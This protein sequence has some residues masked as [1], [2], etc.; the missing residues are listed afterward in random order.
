MVIGGQQW[1]T[2]PLLPFQP[3]ETVEEF[4]GLLLVQFKFGANRARIAS[5][6]TVFGKLLFFHQPNVAVGF[7]RRPAKVVDTL[8]ALEKR[9]DALKPVGELYR[10]RV[11]INSPALFD[12]G[13]LGD[14]QSIEQHLPADAPRAE[15]RGFPIVFFK[16]NVMFL[17]VDADGPEALEVNILHVFRRRLEYHLKVRVF[18]ET[19]GIL[20]VASVGRPTARLDVSGTDRTPA[21]HTQRF[22]P[23][24]RLPAPV[25]LVG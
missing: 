2:N 7:I 19:I 23:L 11:E 1:I 20:A 16:A 15:G 17:E 24:Q 10:N 14:L 18:V 8:Y 3:L 5:I 13:A 6:K 25:H 4:L 9:A 22:P 21:R 12:V